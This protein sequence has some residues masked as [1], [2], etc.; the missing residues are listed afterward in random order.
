[1]NQLEFDFDDTPK[2]KPLSVDEIT[3]LRDYLVQTIDDCVERPHNTDE[4]IHMFFEDACNTFYG[5]DAESFW[6]WFNKWI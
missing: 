1:M 4:F 3:M 2:M 5:D 6:K